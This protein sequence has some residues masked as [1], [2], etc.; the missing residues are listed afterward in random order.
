[1]KSRAKPRRSRRTEITPPTRPPLCAPLPSPRG[2]PQHPDPTRPPRTSHPPSNPSPQ[3]SVSGSASASV[4]KTH[5]EEPDSIPIH[6]GSFGSSQAVAPSPEGRQTIAQ[7]VSA[8]FRPHMHTQPR[9]GGQNPF[10]H[11]H[12]HPIAS[13]DVENTP[14]HEPDKPQSFE[15]AKEG[16]H[17]RS[18]IPLLP[19]VRNPPRR[20][21]PA[22]SSPNDRPSSPSPF[23]ASRLRVR[24]CG[25]NAR[26]TAAKITESRKRT[27]F[28]SDEA[29]LLEHSP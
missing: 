13:S 20:I 7:R 23:A 6:L 28:P 12:Q 11:E 21:S 24:P 10:A 27:P 14:E 22:T 16:R 19:P 2:P 17:R 15:A 1:M 3:V 18:G 29:A 4:S 26:P 8:G 9:Q 25:L 5:R